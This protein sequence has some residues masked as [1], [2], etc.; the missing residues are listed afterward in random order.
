MRRK[1]RKLDSSYITYILHDA[2]YGVLSL[3]DSGQPYAV[4]LSFVHDSSGSADKIYFHCALEG[5]KLDVISRSPQAHFTAVSD[6]VVLPEKFGTLYKSVM[7]TGKVSVISDENERIH[8]LELLIDKFSSDYKD[9]GLQYIS[10][11]KGQTVVLRFD[12]ES[13]SA[14]GRLE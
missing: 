14:K 11:A 7:A 13:I 10:R 4:P 8:A 3:V 1:D 12:I 5:R 9:E 2:H 6:A